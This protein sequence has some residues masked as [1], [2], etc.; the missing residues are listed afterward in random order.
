MTRSRKSTLL[1]RDLLTAGAGFLDQPLHDR[2]QVARFPVDLE[3]AIRTGA[4]DQ[5]LAHVFEGA[6]AAQLVDDVVHELEQL[7][8]EIAHRHFLALPE[9][10]Q[11]SVDPVSGGAP[12]VL[13]DE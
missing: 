12:L 2:S 11:P 7:A 8:G 3:L 5:N 6:P 9:V 4:L 10:D 1:S 13:F